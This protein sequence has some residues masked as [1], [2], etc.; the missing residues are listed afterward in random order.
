M[1]VSLLP[2]LTTPGDSFNHL[3]TTAE[4]QCNVPRSLLGHC[5]SF[6]ISCQSYLYRLFF[7]KLV[8]SFLVVPSIFVHFLDNT[9]SFV[10]SSSPVL[11]QVRR[12]C[13]QVMHV[14]TLVILFDLPHFDYSLQ[15][16]QSL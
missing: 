9:C 5:A 3:D 4:S 8:H 14:L 1:I 16:K 6:I 2:R 15:H 10:I 13:S 7:F 11:S 12:A